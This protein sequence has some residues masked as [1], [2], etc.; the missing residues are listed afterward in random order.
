MQRHACVYM[1]RAERDTLRRAAGYKQAKAS[2]SQS[3]HHEQQHRRYDP[4]EAAR[5][6]WVDSTRG[7]PEA[8]SGR[9][10]RAC[11]QRRD[12]EAG[13]PRNTQPVQMQQ[14]NEPLKKRQRRQLGHAVQRPPAAQQQPRESQKD[15]EQKRHTFLDGYLDVQGGRRGHR[16]ERSSSRRT[17]AKT[18]ETFDTIRTAVLRESCAN[19]GLEAHESRKRLGSRTRERAAE[20]HRCTQLDINANTHTHG[21]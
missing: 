18:L 17:S 20:L 11:R 21:H 7:F 9:S 14:G 3:R 15:R 1:Y 8:V 5:S 6:R 10:C 4:E 19:V 16:R 2:T 12:A 13:T